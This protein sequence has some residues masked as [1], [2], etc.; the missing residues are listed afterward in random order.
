[1]FDEELDYPEK[2]QKDDNNGNAI[3][4]RIIQA[5]TAT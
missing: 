4:C 3:L 1:L 5:P 2:P